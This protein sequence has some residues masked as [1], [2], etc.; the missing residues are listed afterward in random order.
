[1]M[2]STE[3]KKSGNITGTQL[4]QAIIAVAALWYF[5]GGGLNKQ[6]ANNLSNIYNQVANDAVTQYNM[7]KRSGTQIDICV[8]AGL[9][10]AAFLQAKDEIKYPEWKNIENIECKKAGV[11]R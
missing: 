2:E 6:A 7:A 3:K 5:F 8:Q 9:V 1:M 10:S 11:P 4:I